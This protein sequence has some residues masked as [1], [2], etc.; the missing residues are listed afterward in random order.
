M[1]SMVW[2][3][4]KL[5]ELKKEETL[6]NILT[7]TSNRPVGFKICR[8]SIQN[9]T[10]KNIRHIVS[11]DT[12]EDLDYLKLYKNID[13]LKVSPIL[14]EPIGEGA[15]AGYRFA[16]YNLYCNNLMDEVEEGWIL[17]LDDDDRLS[18]TEV[19]EK[20]VNDI[21]KSSKNTLLIWRMEYP[22]GKILPPMEHMDR[23]TI[24]M[25]HI[26]APCFTFHSKYKNKAR[27]DCWKAGDFF[28][29][30]QLFQKI[31]RKKWIREV[32]IQL[33][34]SGD[35]GNRNDILE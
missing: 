19:V 28:F 29:L 26:G 22:D 5:W 15:R 7:R 6:I 33:N 9:Q 10:Y 20:M 34:N 35:F 25:N 2:F 1:N 27:W 11:Y 13:L 30:N 24:K 31:K 4:R 14:E 16:P 21:K 3:K 32:Y 8:E 18:G 17:F 12:D 23:K